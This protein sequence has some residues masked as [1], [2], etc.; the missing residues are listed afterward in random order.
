MNIGI[1]GG[2]F[3]PVTLGHLDV[4][5]YVIDKTDINRVWFTPCN[6][7]RYSKTM[8]SPDI[9]LKMCN[10]VCDDYEN[11]HTSDY[12]IRHKLTGSSSDFFAKLLDTYDMTNLRFSL[13]IGMDNANDI[14]GWHKYKELIQT[15]RFIVV[16]RM[17]IIPKP[18]GWYLERPHIY[19]S[20]Y[21]PIE[22]SSTEIRNCLCLGKF[23]V[24]EQY[25]HPG[26]FEF[27][28]QNRLYV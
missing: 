26:V 6:K 4:A 22:I 23:S 8:L 1:L 19:L 21:N 18:N 2:A 25:L 16:P 11:I 3:N 5:Q 13:I 24:A 28:K 14:D 10:I 12:E 17:G 7:H 15:V 27:I 20:E 9:R